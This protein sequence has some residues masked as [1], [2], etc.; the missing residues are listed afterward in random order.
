VASAAGA[1][2]TL[3]WLA[4]ALPA[5]ALTVRLSPERPR[6]GDVV[7][8]RVAGGPPGLEGEW[9]GQPLRFFPVPDG[10]AALVGVDLD[11]RPGP[12][13]WRLTV[14]APDGGRRAAAQGTVPIQ[15]RQFETQHLTLPSAQVDLDPATLA[16]VKAERAAMAAVLAAGG[17]ERLWAGPFRAPVEGGRPTGGFGLRRVIN[18]QPRSPHTGYD[19]AAPRGTLVV[20]ANAG[21]VA[22]VGDHFFAGRLVVIDHG[23]AL[24]T[25][26]FHLDETGVTTGERVQ[27][28]Q[29]IGTVGA[30]GRATGPHLHLGVSLGGARV[31]PMALLG[32][33]PPDGP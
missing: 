12:L 23:L 7:L 27:G 30:T 5:L 2:L 21:R 19:W 32:V 18:K 20:A 4:V 16:R 25:L 28:G 6:P 15:P 29:P 14:P 26:Y 31:D 17:D 13:G 8:V 1:V 24:F 33:V 3:L 9:N 22:L 11:T 10:L